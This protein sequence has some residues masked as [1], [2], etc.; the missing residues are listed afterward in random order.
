MPQFARPGPGQPLAFRGPRCE[1][2]PGA[3]R[4]AGR[5]RSRHGERGPPCARGEGPRSR[6]GASRAC[7][8]VSPAVPAAAAGPEAS[9]RLRPR[10]NRAGRGVGAVRGRA[11][12]DVTTQRAAVP[13]VSRTLC[14]G[15]RALSSGAHAWT[16]CRAQSPRRGRICCG[17]RGGHT[18]RAPGL[19]CQNPLRCC[20]LVPS[21]RVGSADRLS[22]PRTVRSHCS[23]SNPGIC[24]KRPHV[25]AQ[26]TGSSNC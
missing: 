5:A 3:V 18:A 7:G 17:R 26:V 4:S 14:P 9:D 20:D 6:C 24:S 16:R 12:R 15:R 19:G 1:P 2:P 10:R 23:M 21:V 25:A 8:H 22:L 13:S 11:A